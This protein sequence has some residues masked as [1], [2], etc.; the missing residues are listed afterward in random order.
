MKA[1]VV[2]EPG[3]VDSMQFIDVPIP[4]IGP[5]NLLIKIASSGVCYHDVL[6]RK[7]V[8][9]H[10][11]QMPLILGHEIAGTI[12]DVGSDAGGF[13]S[14]D[15]VATTQRYHICGHCH[16]CRTNHEPL[17]E[18]KKFLGD[19]GMFGGYAEYVSVEHDNVALI[20]EGVGFD[21][22]SVTAC[23]I[24]SV[25]N[26]LRDVG[27]VKIGETVL[28]TGASGGLG[29]QAVQIA[30]A[31]GAWVI[32]QTSAPEKAAMLEELGGHKIVVHGRGEPFSDQILKLTGGVGVDVVL[33]NIGTPVFESVRRSLRTGGRWIS[34]GQLT[35]DFVQFNPAQLILKNISLLTATST[36]RLQ[37]EQCLQLVKRGMVKPTIAQILP[38]D[39]ARHAHDLMA[40]AKITG[41]IILRPEA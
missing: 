32:A 39:R 41:R 11:V 22:A 2:R 9:K 8:I 35:G 26:A 21:D 34:V 19:Y 40:Q 15:R 27:N 37:L 5:K 25:Y 33:D 38:L 7:G 18:E 13:K 12:V 10:G 23:T 16:H 14:G 28:I 17:C 30:R 6:V 31:Q 24:G 29:T 20:P 1:V 3:D 36:T 4:K